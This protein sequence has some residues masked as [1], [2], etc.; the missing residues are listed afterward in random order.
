ME[1]EKVTRLAGL[2][3][4]GA[5]AGILALFAL[6]AWW[7]R[8]TITSGV[9]RSTALVTWISCGGVFVAL[10]IVHLVFGR[11]LVS[12]ARRRQART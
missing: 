9:N 5:A 3:A 12:E 11:V 7:T 1:K 6:F 8:P 2:G 10:A 4:L